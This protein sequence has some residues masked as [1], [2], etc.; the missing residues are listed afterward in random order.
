MLGRLRW[1]VAV[2]LGALSFLGE[3]PADWL[4]WL[5]TDRGR[6]ALLLVALGLGFWP[7]IKQGIQDWMVRSL[8]TS[9]RRLRRET[10]A[11][12]GDIRKFVADEPAPWAAIAE[13]QQQM[14][15]G[16][17]AATTTEE[18][19]ELAARSQLAFVESRERERHDLAAR[20]GGR[21]EVIIGE[22]QRRNLLTEAEADHL[23]W[24][25]QS[26]GWLSE[27]A[28]RLEALGRRF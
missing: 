11:L 15:R 27:A 16:L 13:H 21:G 18:R 5:F 24:Y 22:G 14:T 7:Q 9:K 20:F 23:R 2:I 4:D 10:K 12:V 6:L 1:L 25:L 3:T 19:Q 28:I 8:P 17:T 26:K